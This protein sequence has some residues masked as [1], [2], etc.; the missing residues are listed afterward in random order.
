[1]SD[2]VPTIIKKKKTILKSP[3]WQAIKSNEH[4][5]TE[6][7]LLSA[8]VHPKKRVH[9]KIWESTK[10]NAYSQRFMNMVPTFRDF[11]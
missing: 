11:F 10:L 4:P 2:T 1:M 8:M 3:N 5:K 6:C 7:T 9:H